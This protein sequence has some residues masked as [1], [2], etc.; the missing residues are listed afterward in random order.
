MSLEKAL[1]DYQKT[2]KFSLTDVLVLIACGL[3]LGYVTGFV[4]S[5]YKNQTIITGE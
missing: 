2:L 3:I 1:N 5:S 4:H